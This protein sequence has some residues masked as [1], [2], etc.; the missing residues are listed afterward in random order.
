MAEKNQEYPFV[1]GNGHRRS[2]EESAPTIQ[3]DE[4]KRKKRIKL[5]IYI[6][7][8]VIFQVIVITVIGL[9]VMKVKSPKLRLDNVQFQT[10]TTS[11]STS[12]SFDMSFT[13]QVRVKN[14]NFGR[15][16]FDG[17]TMTFTYDGVAVGKVI[18]PK[19]KAG[20]KSTKKINVTVN[21]SS[22]ALQNTGNLGSEL[23]GGV[24]TISSSARMTGKV[25]LMMVMKKKKSADMNCTLTVDVATKALRTLQC[26]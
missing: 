21:L 22:S 4:L 2:D 12:P 18:I 17:S 20:L 11:S 26:K 15:Y 24:L 19:G 9:T 25:E 5:A 23:N 10:L 7:A 16:K 14:T 13:A 1:N 3:S 6:V 8:F